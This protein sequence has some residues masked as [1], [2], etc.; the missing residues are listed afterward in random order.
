MA[1]TRFWELESR[2]EQYLTERPRLDRAVI[3]LILQKRLQ[4]V[5]SPE[6]AKPQEHATPGAPGNGD[7]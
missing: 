1:A 3:R 5:L 2:E 4:S 6:P 7:E